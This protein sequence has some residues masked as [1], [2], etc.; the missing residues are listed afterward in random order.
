[1]MVRLL[2]LIKLSQSSLRASLA[3]IRQTKAPVLTE[4]WLWIV[5]VLTGSGCRLILTCQ[6]FGHS[7]VWTQHALLS[8]PSLQNPM[9]SIQ[10]GSF[11]PK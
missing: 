4:N 2:V 10:A 9:L 8:G 1:M 7:T 3:Y 5:A 11:D 6:V